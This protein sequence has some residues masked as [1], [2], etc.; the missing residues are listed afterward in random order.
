MSAPLEAP[1]LDAT[2]WRLAARRATP[3]GDGWQVRLA[4]HDHRQA[5]C[6]AVLSVELW[7]RQGGAG[8]GAGA[9]APAGGTYYLMLDVAPP[10]RRRLFD[11]LVSAVEGPDR[12]RAERALAGILGA[13]GALGALGGLADTDHLATDQTTS[14]RKR[15]NG[16]S[17]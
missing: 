8:P 15:P 10:V 3:A 6:A 12:P 1:L 13:L 7:R 4:L 5:A 16:D 17:Q 9:L 14:A 11:E 2:V